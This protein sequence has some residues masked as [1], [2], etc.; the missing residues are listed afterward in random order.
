MDKFINIDEHYP[1]VIYFCMVNIHETYMKRCLEL[2][3]KGMFHVSPNPLVGAV[4]VYNGKI[5]GEGFHTAYGEAHA[6]VN[7]INQV[8]DNELLN[9]STIY[10]SL[11]P[12]SHF[13][14]TPPCADLIIRSGIKKV[15]IGV[16]DPNPLVAGKGVE[17]LMNHGID[18]VIGILEQEC[19]DLNKRF[20]NFF[21][22]KR[23]F[24]TLKWAETKNG[25]LN[26]GS[27]STGR[28]WISA[29]E[30]QVLVHEWRAMH[31]AILV[32]YNT[33]T[34]DNPSLTTR[35]IN[36]RNPVRI[37]LDPKNELDTSLACFSDNAINYRFVL[38]QY[39]QSDEDVD[40]TEWNAESIILKLAELNIQS[41]LVEGGAKT[42]SM[43]LDSKLWDEAIRIVGQNEFASGL[44]APNLSVPTDRQLSF[45]GDQIYFYKNS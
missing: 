3:T 5:I 33:I 45:Y 37:I 29:P 15:V 28:N 23:P 39:K 30:T 16:L 7:A 17:R 18:V 34:D 19:T 43:F 41:V 6:E 21:T 8:S 10:V 24:I 2:A 42:I 13:G 1:G 27:I 40:I 4:I 14:K 20:F 25:Y 44:K 26:N 11:E 31:H 36:G 32:G 22:K 9:K 12:C 35:R 38:S